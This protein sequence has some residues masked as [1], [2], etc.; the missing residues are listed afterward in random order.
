M[1]QITPE[2]QHC[3]ITLFV[4]GLLLFLLGAYLLEVLPQEFGVSRPALFPFTDFYKFITCKEDRSWMKPERDR[5]AKKYMT[6]DEEDP[7]SKAERETISKMK[8]I[9]D[10]PLIINNLRKL[11]TKQGYKGPYSA[12]K[13]FNLK[14]YKN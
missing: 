5:E 12:V 7:L 3:I 6:S 14:V 9:D 2:I 4:G 10:S 11:Y 8:G 13:S 1:G